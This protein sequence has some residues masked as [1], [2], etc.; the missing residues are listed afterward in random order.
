[1]KKHGVTIAMINNLLAF[2][3]NYCTHIGATSPTILSPFSSPMETVAIRIEKAITFPKIMKKGSKKDM[4][5]F[6]QTPNKLSSK[7]KRQIN[8]SKRKAS[9]GGTSLR[10]ATIHSLNNSDKKELLVLIP[11]TKTLELKAQ[12]INI[13]MIGT[14]AYH[15]AYCLKRAQVSAIS[16]TD[17]Q[18]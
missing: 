17:I 13:A 3:P 4:T 12:D 11:V 1:M 5:N 15:A 8:K 18:Y 10:K 6:L 7:K 16:M 9:I 2:W 14:D